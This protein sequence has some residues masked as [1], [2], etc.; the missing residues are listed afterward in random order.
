MKK[1]AALVFVVMM[2]PAGI[3]NAHSGRTDSSG[4]HNCRV[5]ACAGTYHYHNGGGATTP[6]TTPYVAPTPRV[7]VTTKKSVINDVSYLFTE[8]IRYTSKEYP[9]YSKVIS[10]GQNGI[11]RLTTEIT[12]VDGTETNKS[13]P[14]ETI[15]TPAIDRVIEKGSRI[16][17]QAHISSIIKN[18]KKDHY[19]IKG[20]YKSNAEVVLSLNGKK[21]K[22]AKTNDKGEFTFNKIKIK[23]EKAELIIF[24]REKRKE[25]Q[26]SEKTFADLKNLTT[27]TE[28][29]TLR[30][31]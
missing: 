29:E 8:T 17:P 12:Y 11:K 31:K 27:K 1:L 13:L 19:D 18:K 5:G 9:S 21:I 25:H 4:G 7:P 28:Y 26:I 23:N 3:V 6:T 30:S 20:Q 15:A 14:S 2:F 24:K 16:E 22:R 10:E